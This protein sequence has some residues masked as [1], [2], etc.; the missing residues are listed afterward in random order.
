[1]AGRNAANSGS[2]RCG[3]R[4]TEKTDGAKFL[5][6]FDETPPAEDITAIPAGQVGA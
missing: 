5:D 2:L 3:G 1:M 6:L 4:K